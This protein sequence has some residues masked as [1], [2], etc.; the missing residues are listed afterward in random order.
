MSISS[1]LDTTYLPLALVIDDEFEYTMPVGYTERHLVLSRLVGVGRKCGPYVRIEH[2][3]LELQV[4]DA[5][6]R[7]P[8][9]CLGIE[10]RNMRGEDLDQV[11]MLGILR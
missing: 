8:S 7:F 10:C 5:G 1:R 11:S 2:S 6:I 3:K 9:C 4:L